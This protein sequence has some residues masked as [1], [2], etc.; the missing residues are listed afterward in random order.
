MQTWDEALNQYLSRPGIYQWL[1]L[2]YLILVWVDLGNDRN[3]LVLT[4]TWYLLV[5]VMCHSYTDQG[6]SCYYDFCIMTWFAN[7]QMSLVTV[8]TICLSGVST[9]F[10][11]LIGGNRT[12]ATV[13]EEVIWLFAQEYFMAL[14][15]RPYLVLAI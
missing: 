9:H 13:L 3:L 4:S 7:C 8:G 1:S 5:V 6:V 11:F 14:L 10:F 15:R 12:W 2:E